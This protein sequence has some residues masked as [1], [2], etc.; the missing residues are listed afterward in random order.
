MGGAYLGG[1]LQSQARIDELD[2]HLVT[3]QGELAELRR[4]ET[5]QLQQLGELEARRQIGLGVLAFD[6]NNF[7]IAQ[8]HL[9]QAA[10]LLE[11]PA[12]QPDTEV[13]ALASALRERE[14]SPTLDLAQQRATLIQLTSKFDALR[15]PQPTS[16]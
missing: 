11:A 3:A 15:P 13:R 12:N 6:E 8:D 10:T 2:R 14:L 7:G 4:R 1:R 9:R 16:P 5:L